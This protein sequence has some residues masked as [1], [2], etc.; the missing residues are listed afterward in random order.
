MANRLAS[1]GGDVHWVGSGD[2]HWVGSGDVHRV[3][4]VLRMRKN[5]DL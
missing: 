2:V 4:V 1:P 5:L 3:G